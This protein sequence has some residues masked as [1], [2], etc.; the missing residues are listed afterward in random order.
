MAH[1]LPQSKY[2]SCTSGDYMNFGQYKLTIDEWAKIID[3]ADIRL[4]NG[5]KIPITF[6]KTVLGL[7]RKVH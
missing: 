3:D 2:L 7:K 5:Q 1:K 6:W 4:S